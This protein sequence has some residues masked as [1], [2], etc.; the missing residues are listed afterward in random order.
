M[1]KSSANTQT[2]SSSIASSSQNVFYL[3]DFYILIVYQLKQFEFINHQYVSFILNDVV[4]LVHNIITLYLTLSEYQSVKSSEACQICV[5]INQ[6]N[7]D[8][9]IS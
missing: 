8:Y 9:F 4:D 5:N 7:L 6:L 1:T 3:S 2:D